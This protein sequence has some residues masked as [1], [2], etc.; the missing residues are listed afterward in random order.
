MSEISLPHHAVGELRPEAGFPGLASGAPRHC[1]V[2]M[3][4]KAPAAVAMAGISLTVPGAS[5]EL[6]PL[7]RCEC[8]FQ[9]DGKHPQVRM[10]P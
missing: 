4:W 6:P 3:E 9:L 8:G 7:W 1:G 5:A 10:A 2:P